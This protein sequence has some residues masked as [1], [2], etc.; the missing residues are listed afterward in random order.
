M[1]ITK[2]LQPIFARRAAR[3]DAWGV[4]GEEIQIG[5]LRRLLRVAANTLPGRRYGFAELAAMTDPRDEYRRRVPAVEYEEIRSDVMRMVRGER[6]ILWPGVC[7]YFAQSSGTSGGKSK[8]IPVTSR[9]LQRCHYAGASDS[10][11]HYLR[12]HPDSRLFSGKA[13][14]LGGSFA[15][16]LG[17]V[18]SHAHVGDL[19]ATLISR[20]NPLV[21]ML[22]VP[23]RQT[24]LMADW[25]EKLPRLVAAA[26]DADVTNLS[27]VPSWFL[28]VIKELMRRR[29]AT[30]LREVWP[31]LEVFFHG[32]ISFAPYRQIYESLIPGADMHYVENYNA[33]EGFFAVQDRPD[34]AGMLL[35]LDNDVYYE[36]LP[37]GGGEAVGLADVRRGEVYELVITVSNGLW[38]YR[39][40]DT[41]RI[42]T[43]R[44]VRIE[45]AGRTK[46]YI[47]AFG[48]EVMEENAERAIA[49]A[50]R[51]AGC[52]VADY[53]VAPVY[54]DGGRRGRHQWLVE[55]EKAPADPALFA[56]VLDEELRRLNSDYDAKRSG[57]WFL[58]APEV[59]TLPRGTFS[60]WLSTTGNCKLGG[61][62]KIPRL[63]NDRH[64]AD[65]LL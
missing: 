54:A 42:V 1:N 37:F 8:Y 36:F 24:A 12:H 19:S 23:D 53:T 65:A 16:E 4:R 52:A 48:E 28:A 15:N 50:S 57:Q 30:D 61:Q 2:I 62:R 21:E 49:A 33:S 64:I 14:I 59:V 6:D 55:W 13:F 44:P 47:N 34:E 5:Q 26:G 25:R 3:T 39:L 27:G 46:S 35:T 41:V 18:G 20:V 17:D 45:I 58:D 22:R 63:A 43:D 56:Q 9:A 7:R 29:G 60:R 31:H 51:R 11:A 32:G 38:R 40:G 10:V